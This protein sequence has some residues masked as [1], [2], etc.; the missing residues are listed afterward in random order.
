[1]IPTRICTKCGWGF[2]A[3]KEYFHTS[4]LGK[5][6]LASRCK[7]C[8]NKECRESISKNPEKHAAAVKKW[9]QNNPEKVKAYWKKNR[10]KNKEKYREIA[11]Q[12][13]LDNKIRL[14]EQRREWYEKNRE[15]LNESRRRHAEQNP[16]I[17]IGKGMSAGISRSLKHGKNGSHWESLVGYTVEDLMNHLES[18]FIKGMTWEN[19]GTWHIDHIRPIS[20]FNIRTTDDLE[21][22]ECW[23][24]WNLQPMW[25][26]ENIRKHAK[27]DIPPLPL[28]TAIDS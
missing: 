17:R 11:R 16:L 21:F 12:Y 4:S 23:S 18:Q 13:R 24:L 20:D 5:Y 6:G 9:N 14:D 28:L 3:T 22:L 2:P 8:K 7:S 15:S 1:M 10:A 19:Y 25:A 27:C 26:K